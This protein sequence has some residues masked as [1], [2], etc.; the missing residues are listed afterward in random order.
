MGSA[1]RK[2]WSSW[3]SLF[4]TKLREHSEANRT[5]NYLKELEKTE[6]MN[7]KDAEVFDRISKNQY[8]T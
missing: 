4:S 1:G 3:I 6:T 7:V 2:L 8:Y 5:L